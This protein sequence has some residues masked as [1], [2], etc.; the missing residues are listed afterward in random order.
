MLSFFQNVTKAAKFIRE[1]MRVILFQDRFAALVR[2]GGKLHTIRKTARCMAGDKLSLRRWTGKPYRSQQEILKEVECQWVCPVNIGH[3]PSMDGI[4]L[5]GMALDVGRRASLARD[6][7]FNS[8]T[9]M[10]DWFR[11]THGLPFEGF[12]IQWA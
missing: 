6:D 9:E 11:N 10:L 12:L 3:G 4:S 7:G 1:K 8:A 5:D 2:D